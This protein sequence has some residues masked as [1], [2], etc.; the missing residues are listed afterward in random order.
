MTTGGINAGSKAITNVASGGDT[1]TNAA[2]IGDV[3]KAA[4]GAK[5]E[6]KAG[7]NVTSVAEGKGS[8][9]QSIYTVNADGAKVSGSDA[10]KVTAGAKDADNITDY[11]VDLS[12]K[13]KADIT[14]GVTASEDIAN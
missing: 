14:K 11:A 10:V 7:T 2:N 5:T 8:D 6:V 4:A 13:A 3:Q 9:G 1:A 12:D